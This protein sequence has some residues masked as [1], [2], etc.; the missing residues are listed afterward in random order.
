MSAPVSLDEVLQEAVKGSI[1]GLVHVS[2][3]GVV[4]SYDR[5]SQTASV[6]PVLQARQ[7]DEEG[8]STALKLAPLGGVPVLFPQGSGGLYSITWD[9]LPGDPVLLVFSERS[10]DEW[11]ATGSTDIAPQDY[12]RFDPSDAVAWAGLSSPA[13]PLGAKSIKATT[14]VVRAPAICLGS[15]DAVQ[16]AMLGDACTALLN[17]HIHGTAVGPS[18]PMLSSTGIAAPLDNVLEV[19]SFPH[20]STKIKLEV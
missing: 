20:L 5:D 7:V 9:L 16:R 2:M 10:L 13:A 8:T 4:V 3:P 12:R 17:G 1:F 19:D 6:Q 18:G 14:L 15:A 11:K